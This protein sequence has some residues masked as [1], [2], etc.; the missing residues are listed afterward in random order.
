MCADMKC[1]DCGAG[2]ARRHSISGWIFVLCPQCCSSRTYD[3]VLDLR[4][5]PEFDNAVWQVLT[6]G[7][8]GDDD[9]RVILEMPHSQVSRF[10][11]VCPYVIAEFCREDELYAPNSIPPLNLVAYPALREPHASVRFRWA[12]NRQLDHDLLPSCGGAASIMFE[13]AKEIRT[14]TWIPVE[15]FTTLELERLLAP[16]P[17]DALG[18]QSRRAAVSA[19]VCLAMSTNVRGVSDL[20]AGYETFDSSEIDREL[21]KIN[22]LNDPALALRKRQLEQTRSDEMENAAKPSELLRFSHFCEWLRGELRKC[23][24]IPAGAPP[25]PHSP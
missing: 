7:N 11:Q 17:A 15:A 20:V 13:L 23:R 19:A 12:D 10:A 1:C 25:A 3:H 9:G 8:Y 22:A 14:P 16:I 5:L 2:S 21:D 18:I 4:S 24:T 6:Y